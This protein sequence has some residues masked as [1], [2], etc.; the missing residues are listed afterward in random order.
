[1]TVPLT[2]LVNYID[3]RLRSGRAAVEPEED[4]DVVTS[5]FGQG[6]T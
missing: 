4:T 5:T 6:I 3:T 2:H 1:L